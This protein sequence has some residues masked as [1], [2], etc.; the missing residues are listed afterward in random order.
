MPRKLAVLLAPL[1]SADAKRGRVDTVKDFQ[2]SIS[3]GHG[4]CLCQLTVNGKPEARRP[5][6]HADRGDSP[7]LWGAGHPK[8]AGTAL[9]GA[10]SGGSS[11]GSHLGCTGEDVLCV[12]WSATASWRVVHGFM[13]RGVCEQ[14]VSIAAQERDEERDKLSFNSKEQNVLLHYNP[15]VPEYCCQTDIVSSARHAPRR[16]VKR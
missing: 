13:A 7:V 3:S 1:L 15:D 12:P 8:R 10:V 9:V 6:L 16:G 4:F 11:S 5:K 14:L 2:V